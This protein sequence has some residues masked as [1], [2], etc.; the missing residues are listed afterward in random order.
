MTIVPERVGGLIPGDPAD[1][2]RWIRRDARIVVPIGFGEPPTLLDTIEAHA[3]ELDGVQIHRMDPYATRPYIQGTYGKHLHHVDYFLG[4]G[5]RQAFWDGQCDLVP[6]HFS[7]MPLL[8]RRIRPDLVIAR[9]SGPDEHGYFSLGT[10]ADYAAA[11]IGEVPFFLEVTE[12]QPFTYGQNQL[13]GSQI[14]G[15]IKTDAGFPKVSHRAPAPQDGAIAGHIAELIPNGACLQVGVGSIPDALLNAL[16]GHKDLGVHTECLSDGLM[17]LIESGAATGMR[18]RNFPDKHV[19]TFC[20]GTPELMRWLDHNP[21]V[22]MMPV[23]W[24]ND[25]RVVATEPKFV[26]INATTEVDLMGQAASETIAGRYW[27]SSGGQADFARGAMY[28]E[29]G[30]AFLVLRS[31]TSSGRGRIRSTLTPGSVVTT[32]KNTVDHVVTEYGV[33]N[34]RGASLHERARRLIAIA[35]PDHRDELRFNARKTGLLH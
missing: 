17:H 8:L 24:T 20:V 12:Q 1:V 3:E 25:P 28:S 32:L 16:S 31:T 5:S 14:A 35:H 33:A 26:S 11:F 2:L 23:N 10:N 4:P 18:K 30:K 13:H 21:A 15:W 27:S 6:N 7:E 19:T 9:A 34:L 22:Q 29:G